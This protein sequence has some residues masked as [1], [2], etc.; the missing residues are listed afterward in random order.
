[1]YCGQCGEY[2]P[3]RNKF[4]TKCGAPV[5]PNFEGE[6]KDEYYLVKTGV[7]EVGYRNHQQ[8]INLLRRV[9]HDRI[10]VDLAG[11]KFIDSVG[12]GSLVTVTYSG[13]RKG[14]EIK[15]VI[16]NKDVMKSIRSLG[17]DNILEIYGTPE[18]AKGSWGL[19]A[20]H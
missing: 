1:M 2:I 6:Q 18:E 4:C 3:E 15:L 5:S 14:Q 19:T 17:V 16:D 10:L 11:V 20:H 12:I 13:A 7:D 8:L 9:K